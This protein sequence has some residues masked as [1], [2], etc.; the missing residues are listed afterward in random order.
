MPENLST[1]ES[2][3]KVRKKINEGGKKVDKDNKGK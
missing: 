3:K 1:A 2:I